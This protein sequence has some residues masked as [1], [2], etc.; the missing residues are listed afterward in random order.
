MKCDIRKYFDSIPHGLLLRQLHRKFKDPMV[1]LWFEKLILTYEKTPGRGLPIGNLTSQYFANLYL[2]GVDRQVSPYVRYMDDFIFWAD[3]KEILIETRGRVEAFLKDVLSLELKREPIV[4]RTTAGM[5][6]LGFRVFPER[7]G[8]A[9][10]SVKR[11]FRRT[12]AIMKSGM[13][14]TV[15]QVRLTSM[16]AFVRQA[17]TLSLRKERFGKI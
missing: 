12:R 3:E 17:D 1:L 9:R 6:F 13:D 2:D 4:N 16:T 8:L 14:E 5:D 7:V 10:N 11:Y 15:A